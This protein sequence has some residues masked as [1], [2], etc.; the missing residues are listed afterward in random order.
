MKQDDNLLLSAYLDGELDA[1]A[2]EQFEQRLEREPE[3]RCQLD[4]LRATDTALQQTFSDIAREP[5]PDKLE[6][7]LQAESPALSGSDAN[8]V[9][10][11]R[12]WRQSW[13][14][15]PTALAASITL[16]VGIFIGL[17][18]PAPDVGMALLSPM[19]Q[20][21]GEL[22]RMLSSGP[23]GTEIHFDDHAA[24]PELSFRHRDGNLCRQYRIQGDE[25]AFL[26]IACMADKQW[27]NVLLVPTSYSAEGQ[28]GYQPA[29]AHGSPVIDQY[30]ERHMQ[31]I[32]MGKADE[33]KQ[34]EQL[35]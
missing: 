30:L 18:Q 5:L 15:W 26:G 34:L 7:L 27:Q 11:I 16:A 21:S 32:P 10:P 33:Q 22:A 8:N 13:L 19:L 6:Q 2:R 12:S 1:A 14:S 31:G 3:L 25:R 9:A 24:R 17:N 29:S 20:P 23:S 4:Q 35:R 28:S